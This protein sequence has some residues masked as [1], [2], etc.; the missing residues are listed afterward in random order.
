M[1]QEMFT[2]R[3]AAVL[4]QSWSAVAAAGTEEAAKVLKKR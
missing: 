3:Y 4:L 1:S 2:P